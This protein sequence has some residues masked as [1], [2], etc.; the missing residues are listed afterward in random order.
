MSNRAIASVLAACCCAAC[1][2]VAPPTGFDER[3]GLA[4]ETVGATPGR[5]FGHAP[6]SYESSI[7]TIAH[8]V[9]AFEVDDALSGTYSEVSHVT[10]PGAG[11]EL[12]CAHEPEGHAYPPGLDAPTTSVFACRGR[13]GPE[14]FTLDVDRGCR[15]GVLAFGG[16]RHVVDRG[17][18]D[19][20]GAEFPSGEG[21]VR[22]ERGELIAAFD[23]T[24]EMQ[25]RV[26]AGPRHRAVAILAA[27]AIHDWA[28][29]ASSAR[30]DAC[31]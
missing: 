24:L 15:R 17:R 11:A 19:V 1:V 2:S 10:A 12:L 23:I 26:W 29:R 9:L 30:V 27:A 20:A 28:T 5:M 8:E 4:L 31:R 21:T 16:E 22:T 3:K 7:G 13:I 25:M 18:L 14:R 6:R